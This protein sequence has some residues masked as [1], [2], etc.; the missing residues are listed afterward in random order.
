MSCIIAGPPSSGKTTIL[1]DLVRQLS[2]GEKGKMYKICVIDERQEIA[3]VN[4]A[5]A[6]NDIGI[7]CDVYSCYPKEKAIVSCIKT[8][9]PD[10]I[11]LDEVALESEIQAIKQGVN[12]GVRFILTIHASDYNEILHRPQIEALINTYS[13]RKLILLNEAGASSQIKGI[14]D[15]EDIRDEIIRRRLSLDKSVF[16]GNDDIFSA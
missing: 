12:S 4:G 13:F 5:I 7:N 11:A 8:M 1:R 3:A 6:Q 2:N 16:G 10:I 15:V 9:S 14:Y